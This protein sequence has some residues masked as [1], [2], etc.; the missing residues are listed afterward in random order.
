MKTIWGGIAKTCRSTRTA[1]K[2]ELGALGTQ[3]ELLAVLVLLQVLA[4]PIAS[5]RQKQ[6]DHSKLHSIAKDFIHIYG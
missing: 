1:L 6:I 3:S 4:G 2:R 5:G